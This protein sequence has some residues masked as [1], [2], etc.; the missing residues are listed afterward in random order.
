[1]PLKL[2]SN[3]WK[4]LDKSINCEVSLI[5]TWF[6]NCVISSKATRYANSDAYPAVAAVN[7]PGNSPFK[8]TGTSR[9]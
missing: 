1:M 8:T 3:F 5:L 2:L 4:T 9:R 7:N 6:E